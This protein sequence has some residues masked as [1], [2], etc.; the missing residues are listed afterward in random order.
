M[1]GP[2]IQVFGLI[3]K[4]KEG[5]VTVAEANSSG[6][7]SVTMTKEKKALIHKLVHADRRITVHEMAAYLEIG[8]NALVKVLG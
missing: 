5:K 3:N 1:F 8:H 6:R 7:L 4:L 2:K